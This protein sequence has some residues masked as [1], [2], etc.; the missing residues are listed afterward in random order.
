MQRATREVCLHSGEDRGG[1]EISQ[2]NQ[3]WRAVFQ[4]LQTVVAFSILSTSGT[5]DSHLSFIGVREGWQSSAAYL[6]PA[7]SWLAP[8][9]FAFCDLFSS[10]VCEKSFRFT[11][12]SM[13][14]GIPLRNY[15]DRRHAYSLAAREIIAFDQCER[16]WQINHVERPPPPLC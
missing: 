14:V 6:G 5:W 2:R 12:I 8:L 15:G 4:R 1:L 7:I 9:G 11:R 16:T 10:P 13:I 3:Q